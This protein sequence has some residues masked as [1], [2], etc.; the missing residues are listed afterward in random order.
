[1]IAMADSNQGQCAIGEALAAIRS[2][3]P[4]VPRVALVLGTGLGRL[5]EQIATDVAIPYANIPHFPRSTALAHAG[6]LVCGYLEGVPLVAMQ[7]RCHLYEGY[8]SNDI[9]LPIRTMAAMGARLLIASNASGGI[10]PQYQAGDVM[11]LDDHINL[12]GSRPKL[13]QRIMDRT[14]A[15]IYDQELIAAALAVS[16]QKNFTAHRGVYVAVSGPNYE[17][18]AE[19]RLFRKIGGDCVGMSTV[20]EALAA[21][22]CGLRVMALSI[23]TNV[24][25]PDAPQVVDAQEV[26]DEATHSEPHVREIVRHIIR[27]FAQTSAPS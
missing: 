13:S 6:R 8:T 2:R 16:R 7:G 21:Y 19:Y 24:A 14:T 26:V 11:V 10:N 17:T 12:M 23:V 1:M 27:Q 4:T 20:P 22:D 25:R 3:W 15:A 18:R 9:A 5:A